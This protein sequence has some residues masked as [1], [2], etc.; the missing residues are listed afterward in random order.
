MQQGKGTFVLEP[1]YKSA[2]SK[3]QAIILIDSLIHNLEKMHFS[4]KEIETYFDLVLRERQSKTI[5]VRLGVVD[6]NPEAL[7]NIHSQLN[8]L[9]QV[10]I[11]TFLL[12]ELDSS[13]VPYD[14]HLDLVTTTSTH[15]EELSKKTTNSLQILPISLAPSSD[16]I[17]NLSKIK[18]DS[19]V[20]ICTQSARFGKIVENIFKQFAQ[21][22]VPDIYLFESQKSLKSFC[23][24]KEVI[25]VPYEYESFCSPKETSFLQEFQKNNGELL[26]F[27]YQVDKGSLLH[28]TKAIESCHQQLL[29]RLVDTIL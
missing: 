10:H 13:T 17:V 28:I 22:E 14:T 15:F 27:N 1:E 2:D 29:D 4:Q 26:E 12:H 7:H 3:E 11:T 18:K 25:I 5:H 20:G 23:K 24:D 16:T 6:C 8:R 19:K 21:A 9:E